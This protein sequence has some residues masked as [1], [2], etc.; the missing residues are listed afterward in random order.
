MS[1]VVGKPHYQLAEI[2]VLPPYSAFLDTNPG[3]MEHLL[4]IHEGRSLGYHSAFAR[5]S[6]SEVTGFFVAVFGWSRVIIV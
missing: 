3:V 6:R 5:E 2:E 4:Q 1:Q